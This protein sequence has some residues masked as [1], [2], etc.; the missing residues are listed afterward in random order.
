LSNGNDSRET[1][2][3]SASPGRLG[4]GYLAPHDL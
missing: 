2:I 1:W 4:I 3:V